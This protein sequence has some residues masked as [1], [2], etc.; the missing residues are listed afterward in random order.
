MTDT[1]LGQLSLH[2]AAL[3]AGQGR[4]SIPPERPLRAMLLQMLYSIRGEAL[5]M[6]QI[7]YNLLFRWF[8]GLNPDDE[9]WHPTVFCKNRDRLLAGEVSQRLLE[10]V[11]EQ[12]AEQQLLSDEHFMVD[13]T[14]IAAWATGT[15]LLCNLPLRLFDESRPELTASFSPSL[16][17]AL[18]LGRVSMLSWG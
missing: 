14:L 4:P 11:V 6:E 9:V 15:R 13:G 17:G 7:N 12:A 2:L 8:V 3:H 16:L 10:A 18:H 1:A 5:L